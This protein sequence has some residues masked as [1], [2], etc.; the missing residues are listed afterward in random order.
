VT[1]Q[2]GTEALRVLDSSVWVE[3]FGGGPLAAECAHFVANEREIVTP[4][5][6][7]FEGYR[8]ALRSGG[9]TAA[10]EIVSHLELTR[11][12]PVD[13]TTAVVATQLAEDH[14]LAAA[15]ALIYATA[16]LYRCELLTADGDFRGLPGVILLEEESAGR[17]A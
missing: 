5:Q 12:A 14:A 4:V 10:M 7:L 3:Y 17:G 6:V 2:T 16:R 9:D 8:W 11:F 1:R 15:D 13:V